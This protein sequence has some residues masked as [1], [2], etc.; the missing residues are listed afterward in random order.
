MRTHDRIYSESASRTSCDPNTARLRVLVL[1]SWLLAALAAS[2]CS[3]ARDAPGPSP[4]TVGGG[5]PGGA[6][7]GGGSG[8][9]LEPVGGAGGELVVVPA[10][11]TIDVE[12]GMSAPVDLDAMFDGKPV[13][14]SWVVDLSAV[15][16]VD[17]AGVVA[18]TNV[19]GGQVK[20]TATYGG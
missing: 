7:G 8:G 4:E 2:A 14:A 16:N 3:A 11:A 10:T 17:G 6:G 1:L 15:A 12:G 19:L 13:S 18:A 20:V 9:L 5:G